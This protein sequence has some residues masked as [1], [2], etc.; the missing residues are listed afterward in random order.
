MNLTTIRNVR[1]ANNLD[2]AA[3]N[4][5]IPN[6]SEN[7]GWGDVIENW[8]MEICLKRSQFV[9]MGALSC[10]DI[11]YFKLIRISLGAVIYVD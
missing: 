4:F 7:D 8:G 2:R 11:L 10:Y 1:E 3:N 6:N 9:W 5:G